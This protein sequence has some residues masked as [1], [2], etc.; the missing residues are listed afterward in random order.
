[1]TVSPRASQA[2]D[3]L[4]PTVALELV[5]LGGADERHLTPS[6]LQVYLYDRVPLVYTRLL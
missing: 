4:A 5:R 3:G 6:R 2:D 1:M